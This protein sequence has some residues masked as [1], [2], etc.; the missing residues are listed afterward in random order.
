MIEF[1]NGA[2]V[3]RDTACMKTTIDGPTLAFVDRVVED[4]QWPDGMFVGR[5]P[6]PAQ[7][8]VVVI[9]S[10]GDGRFRV[11][12]PDLGS[13]SVRTFVMAVQSHLTQVYGRPVPACPLHDHALVFE[14][15]ADGFAWR[16]PDATWRCAVGEYEEQA[17]PPKGLSDGGLAAAISRRLSR[18]GI[19]GIRRIGVS[20]EDDCQ[21]AKIGVGQ[22]SNALTETLRETLAPVPVEVYP[23]P[24]PLP[25]RL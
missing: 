21:V 14:T 24:G 2:R 19:G 9:Q 23:R 3:S 8:D 6:D 25:R 18:H 16:C 4:L 12:P 15:Q 5:R 1:H 20:D 11:T 10:G 7:P 22:T 17:W 13:D